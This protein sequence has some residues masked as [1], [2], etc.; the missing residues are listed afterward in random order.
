MTTT[1]EIERF[2]SEPPSYRDT[3]EWQFR[4]L[5]LKALWEILSLL[6]RRERID[7]R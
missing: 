6:Q 5:V 2:V 4:L 1:A 3:P 7:A